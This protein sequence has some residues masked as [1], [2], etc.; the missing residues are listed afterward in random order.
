[1]A[2]KPPLVIHVVLG[3]PVRVDGLCPV[4]ALPSLHEVPAFLLHDSG[5]QQLAVVTVCADGC[6]L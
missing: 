2:T 4:C 5:P 1:M 6:D 3:T